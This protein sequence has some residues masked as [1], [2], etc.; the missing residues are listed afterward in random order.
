M[1]GKQSHIHTIMCLKNWL[2]MSLALSAIVM[3]KNGNK[4][5][6]KQVKNVLNC[7]QQLLYHLKACPEVGQF[8]PKSKQPDNRQDVEK[9]VD[10]S[11]IPQNCAKVAPKDKNRLA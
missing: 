1:T 8:L 6:Q 2:M 11:D 7:I 3:K 9:Y 5:E 10:K 4:N